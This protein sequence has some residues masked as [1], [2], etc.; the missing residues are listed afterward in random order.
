MCSLVLWGGGA[1][2]AFIL[3]L[4]PLVQGIGRIAHLVMLGRMQLLLLLLPSRWP[5]VLFRN[6]HGKEARVIVPHIIVRESRW[7]GKAQAT[8][9][10]AF[11]PLH[12]WYAVNCQ[13]M[14][15]MTIRS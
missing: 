1:F 4:S 6:K 8:A 7:K 2:M 15:G 5:A 12:L 14:Q 10:V 11:V 13:Q 9:A 3:G